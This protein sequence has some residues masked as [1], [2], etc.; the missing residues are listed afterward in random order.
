MK[1]V[2]ILYYY[3]YAFYKKVD[4]EPHSMTVFALSFCESLLI[5]FFAQLATVHFF[6]YSFSTWGMIGVMIAFLILNYLLFTR[7]GKGKRIIKNTPPVIYNNRVT[8]VIVILFFVVTVSSLIYG[9]IILK[10]LT[11]NCK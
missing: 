9:P 8:K 3:S 7:T 4:N 10:N 5:N 2:T 1:F 11:E 6:C